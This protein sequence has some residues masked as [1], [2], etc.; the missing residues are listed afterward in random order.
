MNQLIRF[1]LHFIVCVFLQFN[2]LGQGV[3]SE[4][5]SQGYTI[6]PDPQNV[7]LSGR[8]IVIDNSWSVS[9]IG[10][11]S[12]KIS[13]G[14]KS[15]T[16]EL[17]GLHFK[18]EGSSS[19]E[20]RISKDA[21]GNISDPDRSK[22]AYRLTLKDR[23]VV[24]EGNDEVGLFYGVQSFLQLIK[25][26]YDSTY[27]LPEGTITDWP[28]LE[29]RFV[30]WDT[31]HH[32]AKLETLKRYIDWLAYFKVNAI[33]FE[34]EDKYEYPSHPIIGAPNA[35][36]K[37]EMHELTQYALERYI[38]LVPNVQAP[39]HMAF[40]LKHKE[41][42]H[43]RAD[44]SNYHICMCDEEAMELIFD[45]Y[46][47]MIDATPGVDYFFVSTDEV[48]YA[49]ICG[50]CE[51]E[52]NDKNRSQTWVNYLQRVNKW[53]NKR[54]R[55]V[56]AWVEYPLLP[57]DISEVPSNV[58]DAIMGPHKNS[59]WTINETKAGID[60][61]AYSSMQGSEYLF[62]N[63]FPTVYRDR[64]IEG[65][66]YDAYNT[67][68]ERLK[69]GASLIGTFAAAWDDAGLHS[70]TFWLGWATVTQY[71][72]TAG[73]PSLNENIVDFINIY[74]GVDSPELLS[75]YAL[76]LEGARFY[77]SMWDKEP[78]RERDKGYGS[79]YGKGIGGDF[80]DLLIQPPP[81]PT[82]EDLNIKPFFREKYGHKIEEAI[83]LVSKNDQ[84]IFQLLNQIK[85]VKHNSYNLEVYLSI[86]YLERYAMNSI[87][88]L[89]E[90]E[91]VLIQASKTG[92]DKSQAIDLLIQSHD[93]AENILKEQDEM[94][95]QLTYTW[96]KSRLTKGASAN[97]RDFYH[98]FDDVKDHFADR[99]KGLEY[100]LA[101]FERIGLPAWKEQ[102][103]EIINEYATTHNIPIR[104]LD[105]KRL[106]D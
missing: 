47:D 101:P 99:R 35:F 89:A 68:P 46:Q 28:D 51:L 69:N 7:N 15:R 87:I 105:A 45:M 59:E 9:A 30:H 83:A 40:V 75:S 98:E 31:K 27:Q 91:D 100:M 5:R 96:E 95:A 26:V 78:T 32:Q 53:M 34:I 2:A 50:K 57:E 58:I 82:S 70:E 8:N 19:I 36:T 92:I 17:H 49:G 11:V 4:L 88:K 44:G 104:G 20:L 77:E 54:G 23:K 61:L 39:S 25:P 18:G 103:A 3:V 90:I 106:E 74:Y 85:S 79:S 10:T 94:W 13:Q 72:W 29:M 21:I 16:A 24:I 76:L 86:A 12:Q 60:Q 42:E 52:Y 22:Q 66:L 65:R 41:F 102:L 48:Y 56:L 73:T 84:L 67:I 63:Y 93:M 1:N 37:A 14:L 55:R 43:L 80:K 64:K 33:A 38:Q 71:A 6:F 97:G 62:P 81:L